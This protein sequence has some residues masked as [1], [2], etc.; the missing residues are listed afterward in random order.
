MQIPALEPPSKEKR[1]L[2]SFRLSESTLG[3]IE[4]VAGKAQCS[5][6]FALEYLVGLAHSAWIKAGKK[7]GKK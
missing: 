2:V 3:R 6:V 1:R 7:R 4:E 5:K